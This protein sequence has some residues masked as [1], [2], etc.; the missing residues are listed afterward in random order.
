MGIYRKYQTYNKKQV[1]L[2][3][4]LISCISAGVAPQILSLKDKCT[5]LFFKF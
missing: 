2:L 1:P 3:N 5:F 4:L